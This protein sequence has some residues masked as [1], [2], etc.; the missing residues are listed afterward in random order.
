[1]SRLLSKYDIQF[2]QR[3]LVILVL[4]I[5]T[6]ILSYLFALWARFEFSI[7]AIPAEHLRGTLQMLLIALVTTV[8][9]Y[10]IA[11]LYHS[12]W[13]YASITEISR[14]IVAY[15][16]IGILLVLEKLIFHFAIPKSVLLIAYILSGIW[17]LVIR[18]G[19]RYARHL[20]KQMSTQ[21]TER[22]LLIGAGQAGRERNRGV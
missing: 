7:G 12:I 8:I 14:I 13:R 18:F 3:A 4:D 11:K 19:Y 9:V 21:V 1:M 16:V 5:L 10:D 22:V 15:M 20:R 17:C 2:L 6:I